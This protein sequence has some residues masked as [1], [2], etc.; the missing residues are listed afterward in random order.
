LADDCCPDSRADDFYFCSDSD[1]CHVH[2]DS[3]ANVFY[4]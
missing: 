2:S 1:V 3:L 4:V